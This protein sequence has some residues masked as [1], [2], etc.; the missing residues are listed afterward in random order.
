MWF[1][2]A[3]IGMI[4]TY[5]SGRRWGLQIY[6]YYRPRLTYILPYVRKKYRST[7]PKLQPVTD[8]NDINAKKK[9]DLDTVN[10]ISSIGS[11]RSKTF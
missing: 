8:T 9:F 3:V 10:F 7:T 2:I 4:V 11:F 1:F 6:E 5:I